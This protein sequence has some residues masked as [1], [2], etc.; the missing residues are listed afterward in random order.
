PVGRPGR[1]LRPD[2]VIYRIDVPPRCRGAGISHGPGHVAYLA[3]E[4]D[5]V[6]HGDHDGGVL[7]LR[8][9]NWLPAQFD[10]L[11]SGRRSFYRLPSHRR[12]FKSV[13]LGRY[14]PHRPTGMAL[15]RSDLGG[16]WSRA[17]QRASRRARTAWIT[18]SGVE[19]PAVNPTTLTPANHSGCN[20]AAL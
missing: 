19:V 17:N 18:A 16:A 10:G 12:P 11:R 2:H 4:S 14:G 3:C 9:A 6:C 8:H 13:D 5:A 20:S 15:L 7:R 1:C